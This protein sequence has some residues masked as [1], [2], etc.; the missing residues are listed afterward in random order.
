MKDYE[1]S[2]KDYMIN[3]ATRRGYARFSWSY[4][5]EEGYKAGQVPENDVCSVGFDV[6]VTQYPLI[7]DITGVHNNCIT[8]RYGKGKGIFK[9]FLDEL[10]KVAKKK[11]RCDKGNR[12]CQYV[13]G[14][15]H[16]QN[17]RVR[18]DPDKN[19][20]TNHSHETRYVL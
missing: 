5:G 4:G 7:F 14:E 11:R 18:C 2:V 19:R 20:K 13:V 15:V 12:I 1:E 6:R 3:I 17:Q 16:V 9:Y 8:G 10:E